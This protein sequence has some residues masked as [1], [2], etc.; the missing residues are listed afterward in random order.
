MS[1]RSTQSFERQPTPYEY[2]RAI[3]RCRMFAK[4]Q[5]ARV[6]AYAN[7][8][9]AREIEIAQQREKFT[10]HA[11]RVGTYLASVAQELGLDTASDEDVCKAIIARLK[12]GK[13]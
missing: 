7:L 3:F 6:L 8:I 12:E 13:L 10:S 5:G 11:V 9:E 4:M 1:Y 2:A